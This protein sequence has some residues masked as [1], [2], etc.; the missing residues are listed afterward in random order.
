MLMGMDI[1]QTIEQE[2]RDAQEQVRDTTEA[3]RLAKK[4][5]QAAVSRARVY[6]WSKY[7]VAQ[8]LGVAAPTVDAIEATVARDA[9]RNA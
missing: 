7:R 8:V 6:G 4:R 5:R 9:Q 1:D 3:S 2:L